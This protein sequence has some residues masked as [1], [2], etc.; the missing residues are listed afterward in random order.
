MAIT[1]QNVAG[2]DLAGATQLLNN[3]ASNFGQG[4]QN[5]SN[6]A[7][8]YADKQQAEKI[9]KVMQ[10]FVQDSMNPDL[11]TRA[12]QENVVNRLM[13]SGATLDQA[14]N[15]KDKF[16]A[17]RDAQFNRDIA[18][19]DR[20]IDANQRAFDN[21]IRSAN[22][23]IAQKRL[24]EDIASNSLRNTQ[25]AQN[26]EY[27][28]INQKNKET[29]DAL[30][31]AGY[32]YDNA[33]KAID[34]TNKE[35]EIELN[36]DKEYNSNIAMLDLL[37]KSSED[38][39][40]S[41]KE[42]LD[43]K[44]DVTKNKN[45]LNQANEF[46]FTRQEVTDNL[47]SKIPNGLFEGSDRTA[48]AGAINNAFNATDKDGNPSPTLTDKEQALILSKVLNILDN[49]V[50]TN[51]DVDGDKVTKEILD[52]IHKYSSEIRGA[53]AQLGLRNAEL[54]KFTNNRNSKIKEL[55]DYAESKEADAH[56]KSLD[57]LRKQ[58]SGN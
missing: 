8:D 20:V 1:W 35:A 17:S 41:K 24:S 56:K 54:D 33:N 6:Q 13:E 52:N 12:F 14:I 32:N 43:L 55:S 57:N 39:I 3:A 34:V 11:D 21:S 30:R 28:K 5:L 19:E 22:L 44:F 7:R 51:P 46:G 47:F 50:L 36:A 9:D 10:G 53:K 40:N 26:I 23:D 49:D 45:I 18:K 48:L 16:M 37:I 38:A 4:L 27:G 42:E 29:F 58:F 2:P 15:A 31:V 25:T